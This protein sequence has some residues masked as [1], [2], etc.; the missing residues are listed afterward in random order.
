MKTRMTDSGEYKC[1]VTNQFSPYNNN[2]KEK[3]QNS[4]TTLVVMSR[5]GNNDGNDDSNDNEGEGLISKLEKHSMYKIKAG[6]TLELY[7][8]RN[9]R[10]EKVS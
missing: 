7:C 2:N 4:L 1:N 8:V 9:W 10:G 5:N 6:G 3:L